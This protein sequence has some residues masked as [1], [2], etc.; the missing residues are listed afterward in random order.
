MEFDLTQGSAVL[1][2][3]PPTLRA[4]LEGLDPKWTTATEGPDT[5]SPYDIVGHLLHGERTDFLAMLKPYFTVK[6]IVDTTVNT[7]VGRFL[8]HCL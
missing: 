8:R 6:T 4:L 5:W 7:R 2:R 1:E 3:T